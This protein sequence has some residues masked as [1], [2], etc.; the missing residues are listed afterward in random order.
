MKILVVRNNGAGKTGV[1]DAVSMF[2]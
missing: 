2:L 1:T